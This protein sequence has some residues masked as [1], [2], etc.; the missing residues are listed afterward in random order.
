M[1]VTQKVFCA[2]ALFI[3]WGGF[4]G[5]GLTPVEPFVDTI[6]QA[7]LALGVFHMTQATP[8]K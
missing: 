8:G 4:V 7:L 3:V 1:S 2:C 5:F 6:K